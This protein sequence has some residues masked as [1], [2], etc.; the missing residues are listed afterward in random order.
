MNLAVEIIVQKRKEIKL[1]N[2][3]RG[4]FR[5]AFPVVLLGIPTCITHFAWD[6]LEK[7]QKGK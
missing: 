2:G 4:V 1:V 7:E 5:W 3:R 6:C